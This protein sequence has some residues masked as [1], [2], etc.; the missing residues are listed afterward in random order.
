[1]VDM[2]VRRIIVRRNAQC[3]ICGERSNVETA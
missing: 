1:M 2:N 3:K